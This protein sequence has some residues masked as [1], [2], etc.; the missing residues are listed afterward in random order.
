MSLKNAKRFCNI[1]QPLF[2]VSTDVCVSYDFVMTSL[3]M[4]KIKLILLSFFFSLNWVLNIV[5]EE[6][7]DVSLKRDIEESGCC[8]HTVRT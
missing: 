7:G 3:K 6:K 8:Y 2:I 5:D 4:K 1:P